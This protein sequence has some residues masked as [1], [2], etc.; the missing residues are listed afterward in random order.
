MKKILFAA[1]FALAM[2]LVS[3]GDAYVTAHQTKSAS[4]L[5]FSYAGTIFDD[6]FTEKAELTPEIEG[7]VFACTITCYYEDNAITDYDASQIIN[8]DAALGVDSA[9]YVKNSEGT[10]SGMS[11]WVVAGDSST[12]KSVKHTGKSVNWTL[13]VRVD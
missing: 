1:C 9:T 10:T 6:S 2:L 12:K 13:Y 11:N 8:S 5:G 7:E 4:T 3:K